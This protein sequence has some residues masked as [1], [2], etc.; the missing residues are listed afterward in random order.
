MKDKHI[1]ALLKIQLEHDLMIDKLDYALG[2]QCDLYEIFPLDLL[3]IVADLLGVPADNYF[4]LCIDKYE[5]AQE[6]Y[7]KEYYCRDWVW[8][9]WLECRGEEDPINSFIDVM[10]GDIKE[11]YKVNLQNNKEKE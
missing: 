3:D 2:A 7:P 11:Y 10:K 4:E 5:E 6:I 8:D 1:L 9:R